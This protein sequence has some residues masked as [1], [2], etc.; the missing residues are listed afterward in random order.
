MGNV[1]SITLATS[2]SFHLFLEQFDVKYNGQRPPILKME[3]K[4]TLNI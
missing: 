3:A 2:L 4:M 1:V